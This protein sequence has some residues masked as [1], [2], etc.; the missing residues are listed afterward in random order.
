VKSILVAAFGS[1]ILISNAFAQSDAQA[2]AKKI[3]NEYYKDSQYSAISKKI[4]LSVK[5]ATLQQLADESKP[6]AQEKL[7]LVKYAELMKREW[8][9]LKPIIFNAAPKGQA[10]Y[11][12]VYVGNM[13]IT[14]NKESSSL[15]DL[16]NGKITFG[17]FNKKR[18][19]FI[20]EE[21]ILQAETLN[22]WKNNIQS[23]IVERAA[24]TPAAR[25]VSIV[26]QALSPSDDATVY[27][28]DS[29][30]TIPKLASQYQLNWEARS[31]TSNAIP[32]SGGKT[33]LLGCYSYNR[34]TGNVTLI[35]PDTDGSTMVLALSDFQNTNNVGGFWSNF[36]NV[37]GAITAGA[38][39]AYQTA[40][41]PN[42]QPSNLTPN[43]VQGR[44]Y[45]PRNQPTFSSPQ[46][47]STNC[48]TIFN[49]GV[50]STSCY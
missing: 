44:P 27:L 11:A 21:G 43:I 10:G 33:R 26:G 42:S 32:N 12:E 18:Q 35:L 8:D 48:T 25:P 45:T 28:Y 7:A 16:Y 40:N 6:N 2:L 41:P 13:Q 17:E 49:G 5:S 46:S 22:N 9:E 30:C 34:Q 39:A 29:P 37:V 23:R 50:A 4:P 31:N 24:Q 36:A 15:A 38:N 47:K 20:A 19:Q 14:R 1:C 3:G